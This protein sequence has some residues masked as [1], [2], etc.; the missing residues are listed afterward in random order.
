MDGKPTRTIG[1][2]LL[3]A[4]L[5][6]ATSGGA[7][8]APQPATTL[9]MAPPP[10]PV[11]TAWGPKDKVATGEIIWLQGTNFNR[12]L[13]VVTFGDR[14][15]MP[16]LYFEMLPAS[17]STATRIEVRTSSAMKTGVQTSTPL[18]VLHRGGPAVVLDADYHVVDRDARFSGVSRWHKGTSSSFGIFTEGQ[19]RLVLNNLDFA[20]E[21]SGTFD[22]E[23]RLIDTVRN[24]TEPCPPP[25][26]LQK[27]TIWYKDWR[28]VKSQPL[29]RRITWKR[30]PALTKRIVLYGI[31]T[32]AAG[33]GQTLT[34]T[35][36]L[37]SVD[38]IQCSFIIQVQG[39]APKTYEWGCG[40]EALKPPSF[41]SFP[42]YVA[43]S[44]RRA[45]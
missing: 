11:V 39:Y 38:S 33:I 24:A 20:N 43:Y 2:I 4:A 35:A 28:N 42:A 23:V 3:A 10:A 21:G 12:D 1:L 45:I 18:K 37:P 25:L 7:Q 26:G 22:E 40:P 29:Q 31:G 19:V 27:K 34:V 41:P 32:D 17:S 16:H 9:K 5:T 13:L 44:L 30:D 15:I 8:L 36:D 6:A 14:T